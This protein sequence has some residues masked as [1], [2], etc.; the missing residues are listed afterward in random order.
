MAYLVKM[1]TQPGGLVLDPFMGSGTTGKAAI[2]NGYRFLGIE[3]EEAYFEIAKQRIN[4]EIKADKK[5]IEAP[6][7]EPAPV[8]LKDPAEP[9]EKAS[10][11]HLFKRTEGP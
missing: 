5:E 4:Y 7:K 8:A 10:L 2:R 9:K 6:S 1:V 11:A 3:R